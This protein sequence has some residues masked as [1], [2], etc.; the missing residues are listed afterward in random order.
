MTEDTDQPAYLVQAEGERFCVV[1][2]EGRVVIVC[3]DAGNAEQYAVLMNQAY[4]RGFKDGVRKQKPAG[5]K[6]PG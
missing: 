1:D 6:M 4:Q 2:R 5:R 3:G